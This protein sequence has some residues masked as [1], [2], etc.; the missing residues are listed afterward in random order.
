ML[1]DSGG[2]ASL[3]L[4]LGAMPLDLLGAPSPD[5]VTG[6]RSA[7]AM[8]HSPSM[9]L[10]GKIPMGYYMGQSDMLQL[11]DHPKYAVWLRVPSRPS[12]GSLAATTSSDQRWKD[13]CRWSR[14]PRRTRS[15]GC[16]A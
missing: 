3:T 11:F 12:P 1:L 13:L 10:A 8:T 2:F 4:S 15:A 16:M 14:R 7:F 9:P 6:S 5:P